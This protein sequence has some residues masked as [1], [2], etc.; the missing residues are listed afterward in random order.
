M[1]KVLRGRVS[2]FRGKSVR[3]QGLITKIGSSKLKTAKAT[4]ARL[5]GWKVR[6]I[7]QADAIEFI[8]RGEQESVEYW[9]SIGLV[10]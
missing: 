3:V 7:S 1:A 6:E 4:I 9:K 10:E 2:L 8:A 5:T